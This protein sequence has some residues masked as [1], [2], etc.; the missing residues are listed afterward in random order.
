MKIAKHRLLLKLL[1]IF[2]LI[3]ATFAYAALPNDKDSLL[4]EQDKSLTDIS[5]I[6]TS[7][8]KYSGLWE[9]FF[10]LLFK[11]WPSLLEENSSNDKLM[12]HKIPI[13]FIS[14]SKTYDKY[15]NRIQNNLFPNEISWSDNMLEVLAKV[16]TKYV[17]YFQEDYFLNTPVKEQ[18][19]ADILSFVKQK[20]A[21]Y[22]QL[23][24]F[25]SSSQTSHPYPTPKNLHLVEFNKYSNYKVNL[26][27]SLWNKEAFAWL[28]RSGENLIQFEIQGS[29]RSQGTPGLFLACP[30]YDS[31]PI[32]YLNA[33][34]RGYLLKNAVDYVIAQG[35]PFYYKNQP[36]PIDEEHKFKIMVLDF[37]E[38]CICYLV[39]L[40]DFITVKFLV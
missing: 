11:H 36:L 29:K 37:K 8:D 3:N 20:D 13:F 24:A 16:K 15:P 32:N 9:P 18:L 5:I 21:V 14:N 28:I 19:L 25:S 12:A 6:V 27:A 39:K 30:T 4:S 26:Q 22:V 40:K 34:N 1:F 2:I 23:S 38:K 10:S 35:I 7:C 33:A 17:L 31:Y